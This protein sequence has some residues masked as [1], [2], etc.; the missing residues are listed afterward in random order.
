MGKEQRYFLKSELG[1]LDETQTNNLQKLKKVV[2]GFKKVIKESKKDE[3]GVL[4]PTT[5]RFNSDG[6]EAYLCF[7]NFSEGNETDYYGDLIKARE[8][9]K[10]TGFYE[11]TDSSDGYNTVVVLEDCLLRNISARVEKLEL[12]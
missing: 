12:R 1:H 6:S 3:I 7:S 9:N 4:K 10:N 8:W 11:I 2:S 5:I